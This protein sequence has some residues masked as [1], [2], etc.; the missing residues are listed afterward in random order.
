MIYKWYQILS[1]M[2]TVFTAVYPE[3]IHIADRI[4]ILDVINDNLGVATIT[5]IPA[6]N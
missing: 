6:F 4:D 1:K 5:T 2:T 3:S